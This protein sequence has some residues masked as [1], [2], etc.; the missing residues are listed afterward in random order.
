[1]TRR[2]QSDYH[3]FD[4]VVRLLERTLPVILFLLWAILRPE[5][6]GDLVKLVAAF[7]A[8]KGIK[9]IG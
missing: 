3:R 7:M 4:R 9:I 6:S 1:M 2:R 5:Q 8:G